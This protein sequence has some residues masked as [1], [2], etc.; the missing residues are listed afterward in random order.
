MARVKSKNLFNFPLTG[1]AEGQVAG[2]NAMLD[3]I[4]GSGP[5]L[6][7]WNKLLELSTKEDEGSAKEFVAVNRANNDGMAAIMKQVPVLSAAAAQIEK[8]E[9]TVPTTH[10]G[11]YNV[12]V[13]VY[14]P[15]HLVGRS[16]NAAVVYAHGGGCI[17]GTA[18]D[19]K[20]FLD[21]LAVSCNV[22]VFNVDYRLAPET[23]CPNNV[24]DFYE[25]VMHVSENAAQLGVDAGKICIF[26]ESGGG[27]V[28]LGA[29]VLLAHCEQAHRV[30][31]L[32]TGIS[33]VCDY[34]FS[35]PGAMMTNERR[36]HTIIRAMWRQIAADFDK[37]R[38]DAML[39]PGKAS[40]EILAK[41]PPTVMLEGEFD[42]FLT[43]NSRF[44]ARLREAGK[45]LEFVVFP[46]ARHETVLFP[47]FRTGEVFN[48]TVKKVFEEYLH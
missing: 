1:E 48:G 29:A 40:D 15:K 35:D 28:C 16:D 37:Q 38:Q 5:S 21:F 47:D 33:M 18:A 22:V 43:E 32:L 44:A 27:Y 17:A 20:P 26:G 45:L 41:F 24:M 7:I 25:A 36:V 11:T 23:K 13:E 34:S 42:M 19:S 30:K 8:S 39:F 12:L 31:L 6:E 10:H 9:L 3:Q 4:Q 2:I 46:G 14:T